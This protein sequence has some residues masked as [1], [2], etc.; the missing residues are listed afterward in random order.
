MH[1]EIARLG[2]RTLDG[3]HLTR[4]DLL[5]LADLSL[6][7]LA[8]VLYGASRIRTTVNGPVGP[9]RP[10]PR[11]ERHI[12]YIIGPIGGLRPR[13]NSGKW[14]HFLPRKTRGSVVE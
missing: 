4:S 13:A 6:T 2:E 8:D 14:P 9:I 1:P 3:E 5:T 7:H 12:T 10:P 11:P